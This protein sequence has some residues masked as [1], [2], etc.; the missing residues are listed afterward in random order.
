MGAEFLVSLAI[1]AGSSLRVN[2][3]NAG[4]P[5]AIA[6][7]NAQALKLFADATPTGPT[8]D[9]HSILG[10]PARTARRVSVLLPIGAALAWRSDSAAGFQAPAA[11]VAR[12]HATRTDT[13]VVGRGVLVRCTGWNLDPRELRV[14]PVRGSGIGR[15]GSAPCSGRARG[16]VG[17]VVPAA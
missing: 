7:M 9:V 11:L 13:V 17:A 1:P 5:A 12:S 10:R 15:R 6:E 16:C 14:H 2:T 4:L 3:L 8:N